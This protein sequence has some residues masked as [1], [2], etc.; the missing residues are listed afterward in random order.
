[1][2]DPTPSADA[3]SVS[4]ILAQRSRQDRA[5]LLEDLVMLLIGV[6]PGVE[7]KRA[8]LTRKVQSVRVPFGELAYV[9]E[10][11]RGT[12]FEARRQ[13]VVRNVVIRNEPIDVDVFISE[14]S[15]ALDAEA[16]RTERGRQALDSWMRSN[17]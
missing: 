12:S 11:A 8:L 14:L 16:R 6:M 5:E 9:L 1:M 15:A 13:Q 4:A 2:T 3:V 7:V 10:R 17:T